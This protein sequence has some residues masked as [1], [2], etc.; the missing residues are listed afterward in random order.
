MDAVP[1]SALEFIF[2]I[3]NLCTHLFQFQKQVS[4]KLVQVS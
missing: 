2:I 1:A 4:F 3:S